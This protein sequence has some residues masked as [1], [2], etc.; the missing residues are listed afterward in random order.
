MNTIGKLVLLLTAME[1]ILVMG[2]GSWATALVKIFTENNK[3]II[4]DWWVRNEEVAKSINETGR[5][6]NYLRGVVLNNAQINAGTDLNFFLLRN[7]IVVLVVPS[8]YVNDAF[9]NSEIENWRNKNVISAV[10]G[11]EPETLKVVGKYLQD[12]WGITEQDF[13]VITGPC[14][15]E[16]VAQEQLSY[17]TFASTNP[18][19]RKDF[20]KVMEGDFIQVKES[21]DI[22]GTE[23]AAV[24][25]NIYAIA[26]GIFHSLGYGDNF[27]SVLISNAIKEMETFMNTHYPAPR[28]INDSA[29]L[30]DLLVTAYS[31]H[32]RNRTLGAM[33]GKGYSVNHALMEMKMVAEGYYAAKSMY[34]LNRE[35]DIKMPISDFV[36]KILYEEA[37]PK[38][39][40]KTLVNELS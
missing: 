39:L 8:A 35:K 1:R 27:L 26:A 36:Y 18:Q 11:V 15:A 33:L 23:V 9:Q 31:L 3:R 12:E 16:E 24:L 6:P 20:I 17:L 22:Y 5:N 2:S 21:E 29:Y 30:G 25:K 10:K 40:A 13:G 32:S 37:S 28:Q 14:H 19:L 34:T 7:Q 38:K 4:I